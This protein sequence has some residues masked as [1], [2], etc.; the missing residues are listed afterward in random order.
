MIKSLCSMKDSM[1]DSRGK[2]RPGGK[3]AIIS[4]KSLYP[5]IQRNVLRINKKKVSILNSQAEVTMAWIFAYDLTQ[6]RNRDRGCYRI[7]LWSVVFEQLQCLIIHLGHYGRILSCDWWLRQNSILPV[8]FPVDFYGPSHSFEPGQALTLF[9][10]DVI[11]LH[12][13]DLF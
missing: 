2:P 7:A 8:H 1:Q 5:D 6:K 4:I 10:R 12:K 9:K 3:D 11:E 13:V